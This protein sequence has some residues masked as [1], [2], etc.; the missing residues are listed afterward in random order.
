MDIGVPRQKRPFDYRV[1]TTPM[2]V[3]ILTEM[4]HRCYVETKAGQGS[5]FDDERYRLAGAQIAYSAE[6]VYG[7][8]DMILSV[9]RPL[10][11]EI[12]L[13]HEGQIVL[14]YLHLAVSHPRTIELMLARNVT[15]I[16]YETIQDDS[17]HM[18]VLYPVSQIAGRMVAHIAA[19][20]LQNH[21]GG[22][23]ILLG[24]VPGVPPARVVVLGAGN[25]GRNAAKIFQ[26]MGADLT[27][28]DTDL[29]KLQ[30][31]EDGC[32]SART[33]VAYDFNVARAVEHADVLVGAVLVPGARAPHAVT[34]EMVRGMKPRSVIIDVSIDQGG[35][36][37]TSRPTTYQN[38][39]YI[40]EG[41]VHYCVPNMTGVVARTTTHA[42]NNAAWPYVL[43]IASQGL[44]EALNADPTLRR[45]LN[46][47]KGSVV[48]PGLR[49]SLGVAV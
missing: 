3:K 19:D 38:P 34:R 10:R 25:V 29:R 42:F 23:G 31:L 30:E 9:A 16:A 14:G 18:P 7:R 26:A 27:I 39:T 5:G 48:H 22:H 28:L 13:L 36:V 21:Q 44:E 8:A 12:E 40:E 15:A 6:E 20:L 47:Y 17:G 43:E 2:G 32:V 35:C 33:M 1:G 49:E 46:I 37:E 11:Q 4:G 24:G 41:V 45:G